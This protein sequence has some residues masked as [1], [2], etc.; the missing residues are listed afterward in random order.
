MT[1]TWREREVADL[2][3]NGCESREIAR[4]LGIA[5]R[6]VKMRLAGMYRKFGITG[7]A[8]R[9]RLAVAVYQADRRREGARRLPKARKGGRWP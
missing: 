3:L 7:G 6:T 4:E 1:L 2:L 9:V 8:K 5:L